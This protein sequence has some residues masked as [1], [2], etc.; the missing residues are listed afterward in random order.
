M[1]LGGGEDGKTWVDLVHLLKGEQIEEQ[2]VGLEVGNERGRCHGWFGITYPSEADCRRDRLG[3]VK[4]QISGIQQWV[5]NNSP[6][7][8]GIICQLYEVLVLYL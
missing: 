1:R 6:S 4:S 5:R 8:F 7:C 2:N 3:H